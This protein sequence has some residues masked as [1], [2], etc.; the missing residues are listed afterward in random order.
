MVTSL[1]TQRSMGP[2][3]SGLS[4]VDVTGQSA[5]SPGE[6]SGGFSVGWGEGWRLAQSP[7]LNPAHHMTN[8]RWMVTQL[9][10][11]F[12]GGAHGGWQASL[13]LAESC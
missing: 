4:S 13:S 2:S 12:T 8:Q 7:N 9:K 10:A 5:L 11:L 1:G 6:Q 3:I